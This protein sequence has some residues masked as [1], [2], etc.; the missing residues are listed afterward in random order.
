[1]SNEARVTTVRLLKASMKDSDGRDP[2]L[3]GHSRP[4]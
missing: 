1:V 2:G 4:D 3:V